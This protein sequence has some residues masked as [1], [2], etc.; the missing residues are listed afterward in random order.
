MTAPSLFIPAGARVRLPSG[1]RAVLARWISRHVNPQNRDEGL[2]R[3]AVVQLEGGLGN[4]EFSE[5]FMRRCKVL[6]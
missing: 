2:E 3:V 6:T 1:G 4:T 5:A